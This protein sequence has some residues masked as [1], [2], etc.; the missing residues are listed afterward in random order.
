M[1]ILA[2]RLIA[3]H[4]QKKKINDLFL[5]HGDILLLGIDFY[6]WAILNGSKSGF[7]TPSYR[8]FVRACAHH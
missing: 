2:H 1:K 7:V 8:E 4:I 6:I 5:S 3:V